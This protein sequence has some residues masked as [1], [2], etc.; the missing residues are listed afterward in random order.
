MISGEPS[1]G[2]Q[3]AFARYR[4]MNEPIATQIDAELEHVERAIAAQKKIIKRSVGNQLVIDAAEAE[5]KA[6]HT[7]QSVLK[8][9]IMKL[10]ASSA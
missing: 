8:D 3:I 1:L 5:L 9:N 7:R 6:L 2:T 4:G 10:N